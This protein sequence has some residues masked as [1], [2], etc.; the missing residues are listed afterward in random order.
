MS[1]SVASFSTPRFPS[2]FFF[3][4]R[5]VDASSS[6]QFTYT[7]YRN[8][9][10]TRSAA[11]VQTEKCLVSRSRCLTGNSERSCSKFA[12][13]FLF[14]FLFLSKGACCVTIGAPAK[15][16]RRYSVGA[17]F[18]FVSQVS[19][20]ICASAHIKPSC[21]FFFFFREF[22]SLKKPMRKFPS[23]TRF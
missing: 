22:E 21:T 14:C 17:K 1:S 20:C 13:C 10:C 7:F 3:F 2:L 19:R 5:R 18:G 23:W 12:L 6:T 11:V 8:K 16:C 15:N 4:S 9:L